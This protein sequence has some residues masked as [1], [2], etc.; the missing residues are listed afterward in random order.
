MA[1]RK[2]AANAANAAIAEAEWRQFFCLS[3]A[4]KRIFPVYQ[5]SAS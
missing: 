4:M 3:K 1:P 2:P 5:N